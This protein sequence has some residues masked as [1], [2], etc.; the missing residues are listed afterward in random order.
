MRGAHETGVAAALAAA[1]LFGIATPV[2]KLL[3]PG[4]APLAL[5]ALLYA[6][7]GVGLAVL[8]L[9][10]RML[11]RETREAVLRP[12]DLPLLAGVVLSGGVVAPVLLLLGL[13]RLPASD[14]SLLL[15]L[16]TP[17][18]VLLA[19]ALF[20]EHAGL[21]V[22][23]ATALVVLGG[24]MLAGG[25]AQAG[26][27]SAG[28]ALVAAACLGWAVDNNLTQ[29]LSLRDP[30]AIARVKALAA[31]AINLSLAF[32]AGQPMPAGAR[33]AVTLI[34]G[35]VSYGLSIALA[36]RAMA[37]LGAARQA[38][39]FA[40]APFV[41]AVACVPLLGERVDLLS[42]AAMAAGV[43]LLVRENHQHHHVHEPIEHDHLHFHDVHHDHEHPADVDAREP[44]SHPHRHAPLS[45]A[46]PHVSDAH[47]RHRH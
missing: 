10:R 39:L 22:V 37:V 18:T 40:V 7:A 35:A 21:R 46:H 13:E 9:V 6:G 47:H 42:A 11:G 43:A 24:V 23:T 27:R 2:A 45:H 14:A 1:A 8:G 34:V 20:G 36:V 16:E 5:A 26:G 19:V 32:A 28:M 30:I 31:G 4:T 25:G 15:N 41:G 17:L 12:A 29:R 3:L 38:A 44:H 33:L